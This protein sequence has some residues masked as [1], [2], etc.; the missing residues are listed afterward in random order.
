MT[1]VVTVP[2]NLAWICLVQAFHPLLDN[3]GLFT[4][5][6]L[7]KN[8]MRPPLVI[9]S[10]LERKLLPV[11]PQMNKISSD[12]NHRPMAIRH[13][14]I[15]SIRDQGQ[16]ADSSLCRMQQVATP[17]YSKGCWLGNVS[18][19]SPLEACK[20]LSRSTFFLKST[21]VSFRD[22]TAVRHLSIIGIMSLQEARRKK[23]ILR[24]F[25]LH[26]TPSRTRL[27]ASLA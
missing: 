25:I 24:P 7:R 20:L 15:L 5:D 11:S 26:R 27:L 10:R 8:P 16:V 18:T 22:T 14:Y 17:G 12:K 19:P 21:P 1:S 13:R 6:N 23:E 2:R 4:Q 3:F 9:T